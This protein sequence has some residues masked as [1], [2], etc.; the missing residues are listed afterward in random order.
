ALSMSC[1]VIAASNRAPAATAHSG[2]AGQAAAVSEGQRVYEGGGGGGCL[3]ESVVG[4]DERRAG[5][6]RRSVGSSSGRS[7]STSSVFS[8]TSS[9]TNRNSRP[10]PLP[11]QQPGGA[12]AVLPLAV[13]AMQSP[14]GVPVACVQIGR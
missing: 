1:S 9:W 7:R 14:Q 5:G 12:H 11:G 3:A 13:A 2:L 6:F 4:R 8:G 10:G